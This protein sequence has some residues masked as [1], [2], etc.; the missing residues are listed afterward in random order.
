MTQVTVVRNP[1][2]GD[3]YA[4]SVGDEF[5]GAVEATN[6]SERDAA[7]KELVTKAGVTRVKII[8]QSEVGP[9]PTAGD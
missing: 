3:I 8:V 9:V 7:V 5:L 4:V 2:F 6:E 1:L